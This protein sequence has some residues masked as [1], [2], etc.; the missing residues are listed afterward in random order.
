M[1]VKRQ[2]I[3]IDV[4]N[5][6]VFQGAAAYST[7]STGKLSFLNNIIGKA[8]QTRM[9]IMKVQNGIGSSSIIRWC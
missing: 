1:V 8:K 3:L 9:K 7:N 2:T 5:G 6:T 4:S